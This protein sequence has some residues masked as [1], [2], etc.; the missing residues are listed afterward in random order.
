MKNFIVLGAGAIGSLFGALLSDKFDVTL[1][2]REQHVNEMNKNGLKITGSVNKTYKVKAATKIDNI[3]ENTIILLTTKTID[4]EKA[5]SDIKQKLK[6]DTIIVCLQNGLGSE[7]VVKSIV[8]C[9]V[10]RA[11][12][13]TGSIFKS[14]GNI[15]S[16]GKCS[17]YIEEDGKEIADLFNK[18]NIKAEAT[19]KIKQL[20]WDKLTI[21]C[22]TN[23]LGAILEAR[24]KDLN[25][26]E[27]KP[28]IQAIINECVEVA[29]K[30]KITLNKKH[31]T[32]IITR[33]I[34]TS[35]NINSTLQDLKKKRKTEIE[36]LNGAVVRLGKKHNLQTPVN[37]TLY[38]LV[39]YLEDQKAHVMK[40]Y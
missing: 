31:L 36:F 19:P 25:K 28:T 2:G 24:N 29:K 30:E 39:R 15:E 10:L 37:E 8:N 9:K 26:P 33:I 21:N 12:T 34:T 13:M 35:T 3:E 20:I 17:C 6:K 11:T 7:D 40:L 38:G 23:A 14:P 16:S 32:D 18:A 22:V 4:S 1:V 27:L 5:I